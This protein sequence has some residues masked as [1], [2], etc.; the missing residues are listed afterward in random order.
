MSELS[1]WADPD[2]F[3]KNVTKIQLPFSAQPVTTLSAEQLKERK[4]EAAKR[5]ADVNAKKRE[6]RVRTLI[7]L[8]IFYNLFLR[9][10]ILYLITKPSSKNVL[11]VGRRR[12]G[13][14]QISR[15]RGSHGRIYT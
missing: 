9:E 3:D 2:Y 15:V 11:L 10:C 14:C 5:L 1:N 13:T 7:L 12:A 4:R 8:I 6:E